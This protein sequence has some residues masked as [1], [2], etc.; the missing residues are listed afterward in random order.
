MLNIFKTCSNCKKSLNRDSFYS[1]R[2]TS[3]GLDNNCKTCR[4]EYNS[5]QYAKTKDN[6]ELYFKLKLLNSIYKKKYYQRSK[7]LI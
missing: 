7:E 6:P 4:S 3:D 5:K 2:K 1:N